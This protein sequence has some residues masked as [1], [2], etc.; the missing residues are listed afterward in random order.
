MGHSSHTVYVAVAKQPKAL[1]SSDRKA[2][3]PKIHP[4]TLWFKV[5]V[6]EVYLN[7]I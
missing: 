5:L 3:T 6:L 4:G 2:K 1:L 7:K